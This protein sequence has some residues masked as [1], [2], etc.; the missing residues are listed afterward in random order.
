[1]NLQSTSLEGKTVM[2]VGAGSQGAGW[3]NGSAC[4]AMYARQGA[5]VV[6]VDNIA[7]RAD[8]IAHVITDEGGRAF[9]FRADATNE[10]EVQ[11]V[12]ARATV[13]TGRLDV[14]HNN[15]GGAS[16]AQT[17]DRGTLEDWNRDLALNL[18]SV[19]L[20]IRTSVP[21]FRQQGGGVITNISSLV[22][23]RFLAR[24]M[25][26]YSVSK[27]A[28]EALTRNCAY[29]Y[30]RDNIRVNCI[31]IGFSETPLVLSGLRAS[32]LSDAE[33]EAALDKTRAKVPLRREHGDPFDV[34]NA[35]VFLASDAAKH[36]SGAI[37][38]VD[39]ALECAPI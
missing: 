21:V 2:V 12:V 13:E 11:S 26:G 5:T 3:S 16:P 36:I 35:A 7:Q 37:L 25:V 14:L 1:M 38:N 17:P 24:P 15:V 31:R 30:G 19:Y 32:S 8:D 39:G 22:A 6:C 27:A 20:A 29:A 9:A 23:V 4:A 34:A 33:K 28:V 10:A 18:T